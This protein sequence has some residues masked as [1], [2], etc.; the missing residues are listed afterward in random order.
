MSTP[1]PPSA[2]R[3]AQ[4]LHVVRD[5]TDCAPEASRFDLTR[6][7]LNGESHLLQWHR[8]VSAAHAAFAN[9]TQRLIRSLG[10][11]FDCRSEFNRSC[12]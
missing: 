10:L 6:K 11:H 3:R 9:R 1:R 4:L 12:F 7:V 5:G 2:E 8:N